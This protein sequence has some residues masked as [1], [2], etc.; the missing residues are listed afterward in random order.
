MPADLTIFAANY[1]V[2]IEAIIALG[3]VSFVLYRQP[4]LEILRWLMAAGITG[5]M[6]EVFTQIGGALYTDPRPFAVGHYDPLIAHVADNGFPSDH[7]LLA[8]F[9][10]ACVVLVRFW[11]SLPIVAVLGVL[12]DWARVGAGIHHPIDVIGSAV[13]VAAGA[14]IAVAV[15]PFI[16]ERIAPHLPN[17]LSR[18]EPLS[19]WRRSSTSSRP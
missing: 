18:P 4:P 13:F 17:A 5:V 7:A 11:L 12:V 9:L 14:V 19:S 2:F 15:I 1:L 6:A 3:A 8:A 10:V 16:L